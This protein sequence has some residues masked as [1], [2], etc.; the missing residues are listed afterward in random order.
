[1][2]TR[3]GP[4]PCPTVDSRSR[5]RPGEGGLAVQPAAS[6][7]LTSLLCSIGWVDGMRSR[8]RFLALMGGASTLL[9]ACA[10]GLAEQRPAAPNRA[11]AALAEAPVVAPIADSGARPTASPDAVATA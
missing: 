11:G 2:R 5:W 1:M 9:A 6:N 3:A 4:T 7:T 10:G 8:R